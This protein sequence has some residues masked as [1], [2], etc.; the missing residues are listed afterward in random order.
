MQLRTQNCCCVHMSDVG[1]CRLHLQQRPPDRH[2]SPE[3]SAAYHLQ[4]LPSALMDV[5]A[6]IAAAG[7]QAASKLQNRPCDQS[8]EQSLQQQACALLLWAA[9]V[10]PELCSSNDAAEVLAVLALQVH[11]VGWI[12]TLRLCVGHRCAG[13][14]WEACRSTACQATRA[15]S[16]ARV[17]TALEPITRDILC[18]TTSMTQMTGC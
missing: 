14:A 2:S 4:Q 17:C 18:T 1:E 5:T 12:R 16:L 7:G 13:C 9:S 10:A 15:T 11:F 6:T 3:P 8:T